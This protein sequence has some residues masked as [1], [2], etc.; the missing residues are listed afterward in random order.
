MISAQ[1]P[2]EGAQ[3]RLGCPCFTTGTVIETEKGAI[4]VE[5]LVV[6][7]RVLTRDNGFQPISWL[8]MRQFSATELAENPHLNPILLTTNALGGDR[9]QKDLIVSPN[10]RVLVDR[11]KTA[12]YFDEREVLVAAKHLLN[13]RSIRP[14]G[15]NG[16]TYH[17]FLCEKH[18]VVLS[19]GHWTESFHPQD[20]SLRAVGNAQREE[21]F[22][23]FPELRH[24]AAILEFPP[25]RKV[26]SDKETRLLFQKS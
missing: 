8:G 25:A 6:G 16:I 22:E 9:P 14:I 24:E 20:M 2:V 23:I 17:H 19:N 4:R 13:H 26:L 11:S 3:G 10:H 7:D 1:T 5:N 21:I 12:I 15:T 18:E